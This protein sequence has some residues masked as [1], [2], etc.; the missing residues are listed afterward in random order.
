MARLIDADKL[1]FTKIFIGQTN[2]AKD[3]REIAKRY[4]DSQPTA[5]DV[6]KLAEY[7]SAEEQGKLLRLPVNVGDT[8][9]TNIGTRYLRKKDRPYKVK[10]VFIGLNGS[11]EDS[12]INVKYSN[13][14]VYGFKFSD[15][16]EKWFLTQEQ[17]EAKLEEL[18]GAYGKNV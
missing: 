17:A 15:L 4:I 9:Y 14:Y 10:V 13:D 11:E 1:D 5:F 8:V 7:E 6:D 3:A 16:G 18:R 12:F 2:L